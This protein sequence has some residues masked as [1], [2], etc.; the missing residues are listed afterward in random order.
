MEEFRFLKPKKMKHP[1]T[2]IDLEYLD[3]SNAV[4]IALF[5]NDKTRV[6]LVRQYRPGARGSILEVPAGLID[7]GENP[8]EA[9]FRELKEETGYSKEDIEEIKSISHEGLYVSPG[10]TTER[11]FFFSAKLKDDDIV[12][13]EL[14]LDHG[15]DLETVWIEV[16]DILE[17]SNDIKTVFAVLAFK[18]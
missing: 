7:P 9:V 3:K 1:T 6:L 2:G 4:C 12:P 16:K 11:L 13:G 14:E 17:K 8:E 5:N 10:Y 18:D 15:E